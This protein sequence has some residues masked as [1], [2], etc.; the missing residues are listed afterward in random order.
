MKNIITFIKEGWRSD[1]PKAPADVQKYLGIKY[2]DGAGGGDVEE[3]LTFTG[4][5]VVEYIMNV[6]K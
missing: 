3:K 1:D 6:E 2:A 4:P 5:L